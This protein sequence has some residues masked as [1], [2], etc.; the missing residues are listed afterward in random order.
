MKTKTIEARLGPPLPAVLRE[1]ADKLLA[2]DW[3][4]HAT[5]DDSSVYYIIGVK[6]H[7]ADQGGQ[8]EH[9]SFSVP[10]GGNVTVLG[11]RQVHA[12]VASRKPEE[13]YLRRAR[14]QLESTGIEPGEIDRFLDLFERGEDF[15]PVVAPWHINQPARFEAFINVLHALA[16]RR[17][18]NVDDLA[19]ES[20]RRGAIDAA[21]E[22]VYL[23]E[24][25][26]LFESLVIRAG[27]LEELEFNDAQL[28]EASRCFLYGFFRGAVV[29]SASA[30]ET[31]LRAAVGPSG[32]ER[33]DRP[34]STSRKRG[35]F[36][37]L[38]DEADAQAVLGSRTRP[39]EEPPLVAYSRRIFAERTKVVH[40]G[41][42]PTKQLAEELLTHTREV[43]EYIHE[44]RT[45]PPRH[46]A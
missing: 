12:Q 7:A 43:I 25:S 5:A 21:L 15:S 38:V 29:L 26:R 34:A 18:A 45:N 36:N 6:A 46:E 11:E 44:H 40:K 1:L 2:D 24:L 27:S 3:V 30:L 14:K 13:Y 37:L 31:N 20:E 32:V 16:L 41:F 4:R 42:V 19:T 28:N 35:F 33:V 9:L 8:I 10:P 23:D 17:G 22:K 39:G